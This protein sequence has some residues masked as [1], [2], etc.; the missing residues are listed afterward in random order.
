[1]R[2]EAAVLRG[3]SYHCVAGPL[4]P[5]SDGGMVEINQVVGEREF[6]VFHGRDTLIESREKRVMENVAFRG[7]QASRPA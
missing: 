3:K 4:G 2:A 7:A 6:G 1:M 5:G